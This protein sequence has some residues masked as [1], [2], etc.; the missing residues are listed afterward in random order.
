MVVPKTSRSL[1][2]ESRQGRISFSSLTLPEN[3]FI[4]VTREGKAVVVWGDL[5]F[6]AAASGRVPAVVLAHGCGGLGPTVREWAKRL[7]LIGVASFALDSFGGRGI[8]EACTGQSRINRGSRIIDV[9]RMFEL[10]VTH[11][12]I[13]P[14]R[15]ALMGFSQGGGVTLLARQL[16]LQRLWMRGHREF[17]T[18]LAFYPGTAITG[19]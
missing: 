15:I 7:T 3:R 5:L 11:P 8:R 13:D 19:S 1:P 17:A 2:A 18:Y 12:R 6:P 16:R 14:S 10:L 4:S 9:Y